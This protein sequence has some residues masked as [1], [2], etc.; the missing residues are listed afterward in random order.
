MT[1]KKYP[2]PFDQNPAIAANRV[3]RVIPERFAEPARKMASDF[4]CKTP[5]EWEECWMMLNEYLTDILM[6][7]QW[8]KDVVKAFRLE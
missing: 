5:E 1:N 2:I 3:L 6:D 4:L 7:E 8:K